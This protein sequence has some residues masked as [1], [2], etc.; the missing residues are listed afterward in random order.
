MIQTRKP[1]DDGGMT[2]QRSRLEHRARRYAP[3]PTGLHI[4]WHDEEENE[5]VTL[6]NIPFADAE[7]AT[8]AFAVAQLRYADVDADLVCDLYIEGD[9]IETCELWRQQVDVLQR[10]LAAL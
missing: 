5:L 9:L 6:L 4:A 10:E 1:I 3:C 2:Q 8:T 7:A